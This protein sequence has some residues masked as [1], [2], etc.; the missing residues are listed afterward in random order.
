VTAICVR[1][2]VG[3][4]CITLSDGQVIYDRIYPELSSGRSVL[5]DFEGVRVFASPFFNAAIGQLLRDLAP[6]DL[7]QK[8]KISNLSATGRSA[9]RAV[10]RNARGYYA[11]PEI[12][13]VVD[14][15]LRNESLTP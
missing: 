3:E 13:R 8:L 7:N 12:A 10:I 11:D 5:L 9:L 1:D 15:V 2:V 14:E 4:N 6:E